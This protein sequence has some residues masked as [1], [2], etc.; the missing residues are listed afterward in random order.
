[1]HLL[2]CRNNVFGNVQC[3]GCGLCQNVSLILTSCLLVTIQGRHN[4]R[5]W[6]SI[7]IICGNFMVLG[8][9]IKVFKKHTVSLYISWLVM[10]AL[11]YA[12]LEKIITN[13]SNGLPFPFIPP[14]PR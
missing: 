7:S 3:Y 13:N 6:L 12:Y 5:V 2:E 11:R 8:V 4:L 14:K 1:L 9:L 10:V